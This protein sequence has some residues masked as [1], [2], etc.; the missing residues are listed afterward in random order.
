MKTQ[1]AFLVF[2]FCA[3]QAHTQKDSSTKS[4]KA[5]LFSIK[6]EFGVP[7]GIGA[8]NASQEDYKKIVSDN[9]LLKADYSSYTKSPAGWFMS[10]GFYGMPGIKLYADLGG[11]KYKKEI[12]IGLNYSK[13]LV[14]SLYFSRESIDTLGTYV[15]SSN[16]KVLYDV[17]TTYDNYQFS[18]QATRIM[19]PIGFNF[20]TNRDKVFWLSA[21]VE[22]APTFSGA[23]RFT[24]WHSTQQVEQ[25]MEPGTKLQYNSGYRNFENS[26]GQQHTSQT[27]IS[28]M[29]YG[30]I[31]STPFSIYLHP[32]KKQRFLKHFHPG[33]SLTPYFGL[34][35]HKYTPL[36][37]GFGAAAS[38]GLRYN[39]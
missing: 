15:H 4:P 10:R 7:P 39:W 23:Y 35:K 22:L 29:G 32:F 24:T 9:D 6:A 27:A 14:S 2:V 28:G 13:E 30:F 20:T 16:N 3:L 5:R 21:G 25:L 1:L 26:R 17:L 18:I 37:T 38:L 19:I 33:L 36:S 8:A 12:Y 31:V 11:K 34:A